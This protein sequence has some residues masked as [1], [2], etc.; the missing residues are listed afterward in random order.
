MFFTYDWGRVL[1]N[2]NKNAVMLA[3]YA[4]QPL[5]HVEEWTNAKIR[6]RVQALCDI[7][8]EEGGSRNMLTGAQGHPRP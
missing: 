5:D 4:S 7:L 8:D 2:L 3:R 1:S 6:R